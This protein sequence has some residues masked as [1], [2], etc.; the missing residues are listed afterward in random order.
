MKSFNFFYFP[1]LPKP[2]ES[3]L[4]KHVIYITRKSAPVNFKI[5]HFLYLSHGYM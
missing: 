2:R 3:F 5:P 4:K 1:D